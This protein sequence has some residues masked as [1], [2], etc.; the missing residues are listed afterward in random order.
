MRGRAFDGA[1][2]N[3]DPALAA[4]AVAVAGRVDGDVCCFRSVQNGRVGRCVDD[5]GLAAVFKLE[6]NL[7]H[8]MES[9]FGV[10][11]IS[12]PYVCKHEFAHVQL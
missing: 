3:F 5:D 7:I 8:R 4:R 9:P 1:L 11:S 2:E 12:N 6:G 10:G